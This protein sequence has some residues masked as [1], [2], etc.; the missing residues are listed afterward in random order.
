VSGP[1]DPA[2]DSPHR[3][4]RLLS[5]PLLP[6]AL[7][8]VALVV[9]VSAA[10][11]TGSDANAA[12][13]LGTMTFYAS[14]QRTAFVNN[15]D[16]RA[17]GEGRNPFG[18]YTGA[19]VAT[20]TREGT[21]GPFAGDEGEVAL[22]LYSDAKHNRPLGRGIVICL[23]GF[24]AN[25]ACD[26][27]FALP[28]GDLVGK[29]V[30]S[31]DAK[32]FTYA[33]VG[34]TGSYRGAA[35]TISVVTGGFATQRKPA[36]RVVPLLQ[37]EALS[38]AF[39][40]PS[41]RARTVEAYAQP[42]TETYIDNDDDEERGKTNNAFSNGPAKPDPGSGANGPFPGDEAFFS[43]TL[44]SDRALKTKLGTVTYSCQYEFDKDAF[45][46]AAY[47]LKGGTMTG[48]GAIDFDASSFKVAIIGGSGKYA[49]LTGELEVG[50][51]GPKTER[52]QFRLQ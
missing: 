48:A 16:D 41:S 38:A 32:T 49:G 6:L 45:C 3:T 33:L 14:V 13:Q 21:Y 42:D 52:L 18:N 7:A 2:R 28:K 8:T 26:V 19:G 23:Y 9:T 25:G 15:S 22:R 46:D 12:R 1:R 24:A 37:N 11:F 4:G 20:P 50:P 36:Y 30:F 44:F 17:R 47:T 34:G 43:F 27:S 51:G 39:S 5:R 35:G 31:F 40:L 10:V 29:G